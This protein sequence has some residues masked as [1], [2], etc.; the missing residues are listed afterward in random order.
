MLRGPPH[1]AQQQADPV[2]AVFTRQGSG[3]TAAKALWNRTTA[4]MEPPVFFRSATRT[5]FVD[6]T[7]DNDCQAAASPSRWACP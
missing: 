4:H 5:M 2:I 6:F 3:D 1:D 7:Q